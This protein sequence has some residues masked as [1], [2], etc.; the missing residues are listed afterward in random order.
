MFA[1]HIGDSLKYKKVFEEVYA[2]HFRKVQFYAYNYLKDSEKAENIAQDV[3]LA[4]WEQMDTL[5]EDGEVLPYLFV[6]T[7][8]RCLNW[9]RREK[10][11]NRYM[12]EKLNS[13]SISITALQDESSTTLYSKEVTGLVSKAL[14]Q[15]P[16]KVRE[17]FVFSKF[18]DLKNR[19]IAQKQNISEKTVEYRMSYAYKILRK[20]LKDYV[21]L[22]IFISALLGRLK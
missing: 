12:E 13:A 18:K 20:N 5:N 10:Y 4:L 1:N 11:Q 19:E 14:T 2:R 3:F 15:M 6:L 16:E 21:F 7:K 9:L 17:T 22:F 8:Y